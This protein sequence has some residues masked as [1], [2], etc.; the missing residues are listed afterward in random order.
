MPDLLHNNYICVKQYIK[1]Q[2]N[3]IYINIEEEYKKD[4]YYQFLLNI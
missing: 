1:C 3:T 4:I 2:K